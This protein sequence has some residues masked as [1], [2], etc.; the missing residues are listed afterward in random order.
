MRNR[1]AVTLYGK[2]KKS[3]AFVFFA[4]KGVARSDSASNVHRMYQNVYKSD[5]KKPWFKEVKGPWT[6]LFEASCAVAGDL[7]GDG[8]DDLIVCDQYGKALVV[9][10]KAGAKWSKI[11][12]PNT[13]YMRNWR[14]ARI[15]DVTGDGVKDVVVVQDASPARLLIFK[16]RRGKP[17]NSI[18]FRRPYFS[19]SLPHAAPD[20]EAIDANGDGIVD[21]YVVQTNEKSGYCGP[22]DANRWW[23]GSGM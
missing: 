6:T 9:R 21:L 16:G 1:H 3:E 7:N 8:R 22:G 18:D 5:N 17:F 15:I 23:G 12:I 2:N 19:A 20:V 11:W 14:N 4:T 10:Q 13:S